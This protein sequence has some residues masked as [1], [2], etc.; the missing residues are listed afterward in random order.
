MFLV[1]DVNIVFSALVSHGDSSN[2]FVLNARKKKFSFI[3]PEFILVELGKH[4][5]RI[6]EQSNL[7][8]EE[9][10]RDLRFITN[11]VSLISETEYYDKIQEAREILK[12]H[13]KEVPYLALALKY[14]CYI[15]SGDRVFKQLCPE[16][17]KT[18]KEILEEFNI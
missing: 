2:V 14:N 6:A 4:T 7:P 3:A 8:F 9:V 11:H 12:G 17:V 10:Q 15:F 5:T 18:P 13:E 16:K 1:I